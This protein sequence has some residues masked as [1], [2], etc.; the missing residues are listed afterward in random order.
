MYNVRVKFYLEQKEDNGLG[1]K[2]LV[3][4]NCSEE[5]KGMFSICM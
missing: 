3:L 2:I 1:D 4:R 5:F